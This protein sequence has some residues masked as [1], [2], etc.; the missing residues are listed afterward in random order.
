MSSEQ[1]RRN[2]RGVSALTV[3]AQPVSDKS[4][5]ESVVDFLHE[6]VPQAVAGNNKADEYDR[7][8]WV[9]LEKFD[10]DSGTG[11]SQ[12]ESVSSLFLILGYTNGY[13]IWHVKSNG[14]AEE[15]V[16]MRQG[17]VK[18][19]RI[20]KTPVH[21]NGDC[22]V[23]HN[24]RP[25]VAA[26][27]A[28]SS[29]CP[30]STVNVWSLTTGEEV[31]AI[32]FKS[33]VHDILSNK[34]VMI[35]CLQEKIAVLD[36]LSLS[37]KFGITNCFPAPGPNI[38]PVAL[39]SRWL[40]FSDRKLLPIYQSRG[41]V[42][43]DKLHSY[44]SAVFNA[45]K[46]L[47]KGLSMVGETVGR[48]TGSN[49]SENTVDQSQSNNSLKCTSITP[50]I[51]T[52]ID[53]EGHQENEKDDHLRETAIAHFP[54]HAAQSLA[55]LA[56]D[57][58]GSLLFTADTLGQD[59]HIFQ[60]LPH[61]ACPSLGSIHHLYIL[62]RG[63]T[64]ATVCNVAFSY[65][66]R[67]VSVTTQRGTSHVFPITSYGGPVSLRTHNSGRVVNR[68]S[69]FHTSAGLEDLKQNIG[70]KP[71]LV[72]P[73]SPSSNP[74]GSLTT[75]KDCL[76]VGKNGLVNPRMPPLPHPELAIPYI[77]IKLGASSRSNTAGNSTGNSPTSLPRANGLFSM[78]SVGG[79]TLFGSSR[80]W[81]AGNANPPSRLDQSRLSSVDPLFVVSNYGIL[82]EYNI[83]INPLKNSPQ[84][85]NMPFEAAAVAKGRWPLYRLANA[86][87]S[88]TLLSED[89]LLCQGIINMNRPKTS[90]E[91]TST[92]N[93]LDSTKTDSQ[94]DHWLANIEI[95]T[96]APPHRR[97]WMGPQFAFKTFQPPGTLTSS[98]PPEGSTQPGSATIKAQRQDED[99]L[100]LF[101]EELD[102][103][104]LR[105]QPVRSDPLPTPKSRY[106]LAS[107]RIN[108]DENELIIDNGPESF[109]DIYGSWPDGV[110]GTSLEKDEKLI[111]TLA[112]AMSE[113]FRRS[114]ASDEPVN[115]DHVCM[116]PSNSPQVSPVSLSPS[117][118]PEWS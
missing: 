20:L 48:W 18:V 104:S 59:F 31:K 14:E 52:I 40:A 26:C 28:T 79:A 85:E 10:S 56:F 105:I 64:M 37:K 11:I 94:D 21:G 69:R 71:I 98:S 30:F 66:S 49:T 13:Q 108:Y 36:A 16:S 82:V 75:A 45:A 73:G 86:S 44:T 29:S 34:R 112:D 116:F 115:G 6:V 35:V 24:K 12:Q 96:H 53:I 7:I 2:S 8:V 117:V 33:E 3:R 81:I 50:G 88:K 67:W 55:A 61:P 87:E 23:F 77:Q 65:D 100:D 4:Y 99:T 41:G 19:V 9:K 22:D 47:S 107:P 76:L 46:T 58:G 5:V 110:A 60:V 83:E 113:G 25:L 32:E 57:A 103:Q 38:N 74:L 102:L 62:H 54:A 92:D 109:S 89:N 68:S 114:P 80:A 15:L 84:S 93:L 63:E 72:Q 101:T 106:V 17:P 91:G 70:G 95:E 43:A 97:L 118:S 111:E 51:V 27:D 42:S 1:T 90:F 78:E 39:S